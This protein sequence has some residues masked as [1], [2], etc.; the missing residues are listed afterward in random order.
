MI[1][2]TQVQ[3]RSRV[4]CAVCLVPEYGQ[5]AES[6]LVLLDRPG[7]ILTQAARV[8]LGTNANMFTIETSRNFDECL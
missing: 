4:S 2:T 7:D 6:R 8:E 1:A 3:L 5:C